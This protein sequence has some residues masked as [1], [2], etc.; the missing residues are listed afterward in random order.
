[1][2]GVAK[3]TLAIYSQAYQLYILSCLKDPHKLFDLDPSSEILIVFQSIN[4]NLAQDVD[5][6]RFRD[7]VEGS[8][9]FEHAFPFDR[10]REKEM[11]FPRNFIVKPV[12]GHDSAAIGQN[13][14]G[15]IIDEV[16]FM[17]VVENSKHN[18]DGTVYD[19]ATQNYNAI[20]RRRE[21]RFMQ[22][23][24]LPGMLCLVSSRNYPGQFTDKKEE[25]AK[26]N[27][28]IYIYDK[29]VW[30]PRRCTRS[31]STPTPSTSVSGACNPL[32]RATAWISSRRS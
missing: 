12:A 17:A 13:V 19:Q 26:T 30:P 31:C 14:I 2:I 5:Y 11:R 9:Y 20:A 15:G 4:R 6:K 10:G 18:V 16:N 25:E 24:T 32:H 7:M 29:R 22:L 23:G 27:P 8:P 3:T 21:S 1:A 28:R